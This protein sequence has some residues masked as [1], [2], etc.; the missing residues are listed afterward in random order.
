MAVLVALMA[1]TMMMALGAALVLT[2]SS[3]AM[4]AGN[5]RST[6]EVW[7]AADAI[8]ELAAGDLL[9][10]ADWNAVF[11]GTR[12]SGF[13]DGAPSGERALPGGTR[14]DLSQ[15]L[16]LANCD[17]PEPCGGDAPWRLFAH[18]AVQDLLPAGAIASPFYVVALVRADPMEPRVMRLRGRAFGPRAHKAIEVVLA[19]GDDGHTR[20]LSWRV[21]R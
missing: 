7:Y 8:A 21:P 3:E 14:I 9:A 16:N 13:V 15:I 20:I 11:D 19:R 18:G 6:R 10:M 2:T 17:Q 4:I 1:M 12:R 5:F